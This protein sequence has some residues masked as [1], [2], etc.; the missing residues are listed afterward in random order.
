MWVMKGDI[1]AGQK[2]NQAC[3]CGLCVC[4]HCVGGKE[5]NRGEGE[6]TDGAVG[7]EQR[8]SQDGDS[9]LCTKTCHSM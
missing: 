4:K 2:K 5:G 1:C 3:Y 9:P 8:T 6:A 7:F